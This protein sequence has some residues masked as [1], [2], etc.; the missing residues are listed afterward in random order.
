MNKYELYHVGMPRRS[1]RY[2]WGSGDRPYQRLGTRRYENEDGTLTEAGKARYAKDI[3]RNKQKKRKDRAD[4]ES[5][6]DPSRWVKEDLTRVKNATDSASQ[7]TRKIQD[8]KNKSNSSKKYDLS[9][10]SDAELRSHINRMQMEEQYTRLMSNRS[11]SVKTGH[12]YVDSA[13]SIAGDVL[14]VTSS[15]VGLALAIHQL[16]NG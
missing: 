5:L 9:S 4:E 3:Q 11:E 13:L 2:P 15:A 1:G 6:R 7:L 14:T 10:M 12:D 8:A 16:K